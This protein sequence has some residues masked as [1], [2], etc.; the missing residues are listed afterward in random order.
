MYN[1]SAH[2][3]LKK[4]LPV[5]R[6]QMGNKKDEDFERRYISLF[7]EIYSRFQ[8]LYGQHEDAMTAFEKLS[9]RMLEAYLKRPEYLKKSDQKREENPG[10]FRSH[11]LTGMM[12]YVDRFNKDLNGLVEKA[13]YFEEL[14]INFLHLMPLLESPKIKNDG[15]YAVSN[16]RKIDRRFG[17][18]QDFKNVTKTLREKNTLV[19]LDFVVNHTSD[20]HE[21][22]K[23]AKAGD[24]AYQAFYHTHADRS[25]PY[26]FE[27]SMPEVFPES[28]PGNFTFNEEMQKWVMTVFN[29]YQWDLNYTNPFVLVEMIDNIFHL[30]N[31]GV[32]VFRMDAVAFVWKQIG[33]SCQN[34]PQ[35]HIIHQLFKL[36][37]QVTAPGVAFLAEAI[38]APTEIIKYFGDSEVWSNEHDM[39]Y[40]ATL[41]ALLWN[42]LA[43]RSTRVMK[44]SLRDIPTKPNGTTW[45]NYARCHDD[46]GMGFEDQHIQESGFDPGPHRQFLTKF[47]TGDFH[48]S[49]AK[50]M[51]FMYNPKTGDA[52]ISGAMAS[53]SGLEE[54]IEEGNKLG[55]RRAID[56]INLLHSII[57]SYGGIPVI[58]AGDE[59]ATLNDYDFL[60]D[61]S[62]SDDNRWIHR[63]LMDWKRAEKRNKKNTP[64]EKVFSALKR[65]IAVRRSVEEF[66][67]ENN[68]Q[69]VEVSNEH[70]FAFQRSIENQ[71]TLVIANFKDA[72]QEIYP[73]LVFPQTQ[74]NPFKM[75][76]RIT[77]KAVKIKDGR[78]SLKPYQFYWLTNK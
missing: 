29:G 15:G 68:T 54:A 25:T 56:R 20:E 69:L 12:L 10:W 64:E 47:L 32:D 41:M 23:K 76:D 44:A 61:E 59:I 71:N 58:Y 45:I 63:P 28:A 43:T 42:S 49:F 33:T 75:I 74:V 55:L 62:K 37:A 53:L 1:P 60:K 40:N 34:L 77:G 18:N 22:A 35:A 78:L 2:L 5:L 8:K 48:G 50:G 16:Y 19:M 67:D 21:W 11:E 65:M 73:H 7:S 51:P 66:A 38:V 6:K 70:V 17:T 24:E 31:M 39:A 26:M 46:I 14:G 13:D 30:A 3:L 52:R 9:E 57:L 72:D 27:R 36:C 4:L